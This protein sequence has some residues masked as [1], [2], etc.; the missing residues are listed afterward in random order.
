[1]QSVPQLAVHPPSRPCPSLCLSVLPVEHE[2]VNVLLVVLF[3]AVHLLGDW[4]RQGIG[5]TLWKE[6]AWH[7]P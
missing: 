5:V 3:C 6:D 2:G 1:M 7:D 4:M